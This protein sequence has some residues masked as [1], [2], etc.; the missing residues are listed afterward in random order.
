LDD[1]ASHALARVSESLRG[2]TAEIEEEQVPN[3]TKEAPPTKVEQQERMEAHSS[4]VPTRVPA[5]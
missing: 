5:L 4:T 3:Q 2:R 1:A